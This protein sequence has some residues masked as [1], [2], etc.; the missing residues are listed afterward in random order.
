MKKILSGNDT[1]VYEKLIKF[2]AHLVSKSLL[3]CFFRV[4]SGKNLAYII[5]NREPLLKGKTVQFTLFRQ[6]FKEKKIFSLLKN[7]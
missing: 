7:S 3:Q 1:W 6:L 2:F 4:L 5:K